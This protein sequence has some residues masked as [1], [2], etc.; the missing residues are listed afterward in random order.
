[1][2]T[3]LI[4][5]VVIGLRC[6]V[7]VAQAPS[8][9]LR[10]EIGLEATHWV[11]DGG[12][13]S[14]TSQTRWGPT[15]RF[16]LRPSAGSRVSALA[17]LSYTSEGTFEPGVAGGAVELAVRFARVGET[18]RRLNGFV[19]ASLGLL[20]FDADHQERELAACWASPTCRFEGIAFGSGWRP[21]VGGGIG[22][23][24]PVSANLVLQPQGHLLRPL[25]SGPAG[26]EGNSV[27][28]HVGLGLAR[29]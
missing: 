18:R 25:G 9:G 8:S 13:Y 23:D 29:R 27:L 7:C 10:A 1:M 3:S 12:T 4:L 5:A 19:T 20:R 26:P 17:A 28:L 24:L 11:L 14:T 21:V 2:R 15:V 16:G 6:V 22:F